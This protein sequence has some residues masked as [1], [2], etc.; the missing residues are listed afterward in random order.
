MDGPWVGLSVGLS[1]VERST[2]IL[3]G[4]YSYSNHETGEVH[5]TVQERGGIEV[6]LSR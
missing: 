3:L 1:E 5:S 6:T 2:S 4:Q